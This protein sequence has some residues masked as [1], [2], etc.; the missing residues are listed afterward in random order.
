MKNMKDSGENW[1]GKIPAHWYIGRIDSFYSLRNTKVSDY[2]YQP[3]SV[4]MKGVVPQLESAAKTNAHDDRKL[5]KKGDFVINSRS[6]RRGSCGISDYDGSVSLINTVLSPRGEMNPKYFDWLFHTIQFADEFYRSGHGIVDDL[7]TTNY[8]DMKKIN[9]PVP[10]IQEQCKISNYLDKKCSD[11]DFLIQKIRSE[12]ETLESYKMSIITEAVTKGIDKNVVL[13]KCENDWVEEIPENWEIIKLKH[14]FTFGKGLPITKAD[15]IDDGLPIV[16]YGQIHSKENTK[17]NIENNLIRYVDP[18]F[19]IRF[20]QCKTKQYDFIF[21]DT[22]EDLEG[23]GNCVYV[24]NNEKIFAG[25]HSI[26]LHSKTMRDNRFFAYL[27]TT[28]IWRKQIRNLVNGIKVFS[29]TRG[30]LERVSVIQPPSEF[31]ER[32]ANYLDSK[33]EIINKAIELKKSQLNILS[34][35]KKSVIFEYITGKKEILMQ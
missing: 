35:Y 22:S 14:L 5:V 3:L 6:D 12:I 9:I 13:E 11:I 1:I 30:V 25:Y 24:R 16:S 20:P 19:A 34:E 23:C 26:I 27:F 4:T 18:S 33:C 17:T 21:A 28:D 10:P 8:Q 7:W 29:I 15:L 32:I 31:Q 2:D